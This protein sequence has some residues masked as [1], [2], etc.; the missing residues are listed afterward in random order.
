MA[1]ILAV[2]IA[3]VDIVN[4]TDGYP[5]EDSEVRAVSQQTRRGGNAANTLAVLS[6][7]G[8]QCSWAGAITDDQ[9]HAI[10]QQDLIKHGVNMR[11]CQL[12][13]G[14]STPTSYIT[15]NQNNGSRTIVHYRNLPEL[16]ATPFT[17]LD[18]NSY[19]WVHFEA[20]NI[21]ETRKMIE[22]SK[23]HYPDIPVSIEIEKN[24][25]EIESLFTPPI[26]TNTIYF[27][28][29]HFARQYNF[30]SPQTLLAHYQPHLPGDLLICTWG[31]Q[32]AYAM[33]NNHFYHAKAY[34]PANVVDTIGAGDTFNAGFIDACLAN[35]D[36]QNALDVA[37]RLAGKKCGISGL[38]N[39]LQN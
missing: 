6:Q 27:F 32:G 20:R 10:V 7:L 29:S 37:S 17:Q 26:S 18:L 11:H 2:G 15:L 22:Y 25:D 38:H 33:E 12:F 30:D 28:S 9:N 36:T 35:L 1:N 13:P 19:Q 24:R 31:T 4:V 16:N 3:T 8:H 5:H 14:Q 39:I 34:P 23:I 21:P